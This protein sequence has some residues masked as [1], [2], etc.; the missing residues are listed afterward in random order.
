MS[1]I[2]PYLVAALAL[3]L[4]ACTNPYDPVERGLGGGIMGAAS[5]AAIRYGLPSDVGRPASPGSPGYGYQSRPPYSPDPGPGYGYPGYGYPSG[6]A[7]D[8]PSGTTEYGI[9]PAG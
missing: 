7:E 6:A 5:G 3:G 9:E 2:A 8:W 4:A 1:Q